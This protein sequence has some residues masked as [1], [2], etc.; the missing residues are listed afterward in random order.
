[1]SE[2]SDR[3]HSP[4]EPED[5][6]RADFYALLARLF[7]NAPSAILLRSIA[8]AGPLTPATGSSEN[9]S[10]AARL[11]EAWNVLRSASESIDWRTA[12]FEY[13]ALFIGVGRSE[14]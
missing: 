3:E 1:M 5:Q 14:V 10:A 8:E 11:A 9:A 13:D 7:A 12:S 6:A 4:I 2:A